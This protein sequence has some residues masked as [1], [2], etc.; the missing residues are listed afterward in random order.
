MIGFVRNS[1]TATIVS[2]CVALPA[3]AGDGATVPEANTISLISLALAGVI[4][5]RR[6]SMRKR[7]D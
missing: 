7:K 4:V 3:H 1:M 2:L 6:L 5:G